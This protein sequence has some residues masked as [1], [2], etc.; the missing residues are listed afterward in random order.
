MTR[1]REEWERRSVEL[2]Q[3][4]AALDRRTADLEKQAQEI[5]RRR[6]ELERREAKLE[7]V[8]GQSEKATRDL[9]QLKQERIQEIRKSGKTQTVNLSKP[10]PVLLMYWTAEPGADAQ[11]RFMPDV[12]E[13]DKPLLRELDEGFAKRI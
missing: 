1:L 7:Q 8:A 2:Q 10:L 11:V 13:R 4:Q 6:V 5:D 9:E 3:R 12:Y